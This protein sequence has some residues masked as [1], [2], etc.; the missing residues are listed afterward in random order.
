MSGR[1]WLGLLVASLVCLI[2]ALCSHFA[3][4]DNGHT[5]EG[6]VGRFYQ[7][8][9][10]PDAPKI[11]CCSNEDCGPVASRVVDGK[12]QAKVGDDW[13]TIPDYKIEQDK[14]SPDGM[15]HLCGRR[16]AF[17]DFSVFCFIRGS[18]T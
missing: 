1:G 9:K 17:G 15:S 4:A 18:G 2:M 13:I 10:M 6:A 8:W 11:S 12:W 5:H 16:S 3:K 7:S 14:D